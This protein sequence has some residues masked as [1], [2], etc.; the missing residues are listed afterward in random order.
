MELPLH[1]P[2]PETDMTSE[3]KVAR[4]KRSLLE[5]ATALGNVS[6]ACRVMGY[7]RQQFY[8]I[9]RNFQT[10][11]ADGL[12]DRLA[13]ARAPHPH[14]VGAEIE[15]AVLDQA[16]AHP[17][18]G[19]LRVA[20]EL[21]LRG[22]QVSAGGVRGVWQRHGLLTQHERLLR[23]EQATAERRLALSDEQ[24]RLLERFSPE[25]RERNSKASR[26]GPPGCAGRSPTAS[27][28]ACIAPCSTSTSGSKAGAPG[29]RPSRR[30]RPF[31]PPTSKATITTGP[32]RAAACRPHARPGLQRRPAAHPGQGGHRQTT[33]PKQGRLTQPPSGTLR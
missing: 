30:C 19:P 24:I 32:T 11:G 14:R 8:E 7:S 20:Q 18:H 26:T 27:S 13:G 22:L 29:S 15:P 1:P 10:Y 23:L 2:E 31:S 3:Q 6:K 16:L 28:S 5:L 9:R 12:L 25:F 4:R 33:N 17:C 21:M